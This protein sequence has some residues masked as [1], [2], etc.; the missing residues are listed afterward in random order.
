VER[1][2]KWYV[3]YTRSRAEKKISEL[4]QKRGHEHYLPIIKELRKW[5]DRK[6]VVEKPLFSSY[7]FIKAELHEIQ[8]LIQWIPGLISCVRYN[9][10][11]AIL[12]NEEIAKIIKFVAS[13]MPL[14]CGNA[15]NLLE[16][17]KVEVVSGPLKG[18]NGEV[19]NIGNSDYLVMRIKT[20]NQYLK[21]Q[22]SKEI[23]KKTGE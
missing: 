5:S 3:F 6:K 7:I 19:I 18:I 13:G 15:E 20:I 11:P 14:E 4:L 22:V 12:T 1:E 21:L 8:E 16:G 23:L 9:S 10:Q 17:D 2:K